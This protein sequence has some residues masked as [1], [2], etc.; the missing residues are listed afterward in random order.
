MAEI[1]SSDMQ[2]DPQKAIDTDYEDLMGKIKQA[3]NLSSAAAVPIKRQRLSAQTIRIM[4]RRTRMKEEGR[5]G[6]DE[7]KTLCTMIR[8]KVREDY[9]GF[10]QKR[11]REAAIKRASLKAME[12]DVPLRQHVPS[13]LKDERGVRTT[14]RSYI[15]Q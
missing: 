10:K 11:L 2:M 9:E 8:Q 1:A 7:Y 13:A 4:T 3:M 15:K 12:R 14:K 5:L 6:S